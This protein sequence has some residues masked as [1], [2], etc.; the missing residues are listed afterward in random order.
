MLGSV[1]EGLPS[2]NVD[3][4]IT[5]RDTEFKEVSKETNRKYDVRKD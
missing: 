1:L 3:S 2:G 5:I 4:I